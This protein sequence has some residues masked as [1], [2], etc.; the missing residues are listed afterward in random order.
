MNDV[1]IYLEFVRKKEYDAVF[2][3]SNDMLFFQGRR[4]KTAYRNHYVHRAVQQNTPRSATLISQLSLV[5]VFDTN[6]MPYIVPW[7]LSSAVTVS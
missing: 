3:P 1:N 4:Q 7:L 6:S 2:P 5:P